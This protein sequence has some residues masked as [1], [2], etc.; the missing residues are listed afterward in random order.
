MYSVFDTEPV[1]WPSVEGM[2]HTVARFRSL[3]NIEQTR[4]ML[5]QERFVQERIHKLSTTLIKLKKENREKQMIAL[6][7]R[8]LDGEHITEPLNTMDLNDIGWVINMHLVEIN[9]RIEAIK[10]EGGASSSSIAQPIAD[11]HHLVAQEVPVFHI[12]FVST[13]ASGSKVQHVFPQ[14]YQG[15]IIGHNEVQAAGS[16]IGTIAPGLFNFQVGGSSNCGL[17][18]GMFK[19]EVGASSNSVLTLG[20]FNNRQGGATGSDAIVTS[21][22]NLPTGSPS[23]GV[24]APG[25]FTFQGGASSSNVVGSDRFNFKGGP[26]TGCVVPPAMFNFQG[27][28]FSSHAMTSGMLNYQAGASRNC[29]VD[30]SEVAFQAG[31]SRN[32]TEAPAGRSNYQQK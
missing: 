32:N 13:E 17:A 4:R 2:Q 28:A 30:S 31:V 3:P 23:R 12:P 11:D 19:Y 21:M 5:N 25:M 20:M 22:L 10:K 26:S 24:V 8:I 14:L 18:P 9:N 16:N 7:Y 29:V 6:M 1:V 27:G 15:P